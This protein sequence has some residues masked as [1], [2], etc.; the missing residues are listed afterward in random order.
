MVTRLGYKKSWESRFTNSQFSK[1]LSTSESQQPN[2]KPVERRGAASDQNAS[3]SF[4]APFCP[5]FGRLCQE[6]Y[7]R[8]KVHTFLGKMTLFLEFFRIFHVIT[9]QLCKII[10]L[11]TFIISV[12]LIIRE[13]MPV[14]HYVKTKVRIPTNWL[15]TKSYVGALK[16]GCIFP[17]FVN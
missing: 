16:K 5:F 11:K 6:D 15:Q 14:R 12:Y 9:N 17:H 13:Y 8:N 4:M 7:K 10:L 2:S 1:P 3:A